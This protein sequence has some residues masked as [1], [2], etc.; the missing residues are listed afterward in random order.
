[1]GQFQ[2]ARAMSDAE[3]GPS[4]SR[5]SRRNGGNAPRVAS[6]S[7]AIANTEASGSTSREPSS[8]HSLTPLGRTKRM[9]EELE[10]LNTP[11]YGGNLFTAP[12]S[13]KRETKKNTRFSPDLETHKKHKT[14]A[15][16]LNEAAAAFEEKPKQ[17]RKRH[18]LSLKDTVG[19]LF[20]MRKHLVVR[21]FC[22]PPT[23][24]GKGAELHRRLPKEQWGGGKASTSGK[25]AGRRSTLGDAPSSSLASFHFEPVAEAEDAVEDHPPRGRTKKKASE[26]R[27][28]KM[29]TRKSRGG[30]SKSVSMELSSNGEPQ[31]N[32]EI[33]EEI[34]VEESVKKGRKGRLSLPPP[35][36]SSSIA[37]TGRR[38]KSGVSRAIKQELMDEEEDQ[39]RGGRRER[40][41]TITTK[42][43][44][45]ESEEGPS[46][47]APPDRSRSRKRGRH[48][49][50]TKDDDSAEHE[51]AS[52]PPAKRKNT[53]RST[54]STV[55]EEEMEESEIE[56]KK[57][58]TGKHRNRRTVSQLLMDDLREGEKGE[59]GEEETEE[60][61]MVT[62]R[63]SFRGH[64]DGSGEGA[65]TTTRTAKIPTITRKGA[66][67]EAGKDASLDPGHEVAHLM[68]REEVNDER[69]EDEEKDEREEEEDEGGEEEPIRP[70]PSMLLDESTG[71]KS[72]YEE[73]SS[74]ELEGE[75]T[76]EGMKEGE[77]EQTTPAR[78]GRGR[79]RKDGMPFKTNTTPK[80]KRIEQEIVA[81]ISRPRR[82]VALN[83]K[84]AD[85]ITETATRSARRASAGAPTPVTPRTLAAAGV[86]L[87][88]P[89]PPP[90]PEVKAAPG[91]ALH[92]MRAL[93]KKKLP[94]MRSPSP[95]LPSP[96]G[97]SGSLRSTTAA[98]TNLTDA[99]PIQQGDGEEKEKK[100]EEEEEEQ[101]G[102]SRPPQRQRRSDES[103]AK[104]DQKDEEEGGEK[105][106]QS[107][108]LPRIVQYSSI[109]SNLSSKK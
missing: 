66:R 79:P 87:R 7:P 58:T 1:F 52:E 81:P 10:R 53:R 11:S 70:S 17:T 14:A 15:E 104:P 34:A 46:S 6:D 3:G 25:T 43:E 42:A 12:S 48:S 24:G 57:N 61:G 44:P 86:T 8:A 55:D 93:K 5:S 67:L 36:P 62:R 99:P 89:S 77:E 76:E 56:T 109:T 2:L 69:M 28:T 106:E 30:H 20:S 19:K 60:G 78:R 38:S 82:S 23:F 29:E 88:L 91:S 73:E 85:F 37:G 64:V 49:R 74:R 96:G 50:S 22:L 102:P 107:T 103:A 54:R 40:E 4:S 90:I 71:E 41:T 51:M 21:D 18:V 94:S 45:D 59:D 72:G 68:N 27:D 32:D 97:R 31:E 84:M 26:E 16:K 98:T 39:S 63:R 13:R 47:S 100:E 35:P 80:P 95:P 83:Q 92:I 33:E 75:E 108:D 101:P 65:A 105:E 9:R